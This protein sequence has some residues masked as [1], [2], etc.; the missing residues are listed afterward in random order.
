MSRSSLE[1][2]LLIIDSSPE[3]AELARLS[4]GG[5]SVRV[6]W[7]NDGASGLRMTASELP[8]LVILG[9]QLPGLSGAEVLRRL[10]ERARQ[11]HFPIIVLSPVADTSAEIECLEEGADDFLVKPIDP[12]LLR[13]R[14][15]AVVRRARLRGNTRGLLVLGNVKLN[16]LSRALDVHGTTAAVLTP[17]ECT[18][19]VYLMS[20]LGE[21]IDGK[22]LYKKMY[23]T[24]PAEGS[25]LLKAHI[26]NV[27]HKL[28]QYSGLIQTVKEEGYRFNL[29]LANSEAPDLPVKTG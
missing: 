1:T 7:A 21:I 14:V 28:G 29:E 2:T 12:A 6:L 11:E 17:L 19:L 4:F 27:R 16:T 8:D 22:N 15:H 10:R 24:W 18:V 5:E 26:R 25:G 13:A 20:A 23:H 9:W 3:T